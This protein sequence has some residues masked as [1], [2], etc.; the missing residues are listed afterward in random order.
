MDF[1]AFRAPQPFET[2]GT[3]INFLNNYSSCTT[4]MARDNCVVHEEGPYRVTAPPGTYRIFATYQSGNNHLRG[5]IF[6]VVADMVV[7]GLPGISAQSA[8]DSAAG[9]ESLMSPAY[10]EP[11]PGGGGEGDSDPTPCESCPIPIAE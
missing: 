4:G 8:T 11:P 5:D 3:R 9:T 7:P 2:T 6:D 1:E 10:S